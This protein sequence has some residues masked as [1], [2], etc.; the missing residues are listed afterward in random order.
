MKGEIR[1][2]DRQVNQQ[3]TSVGRPT[4]SKNKQKMEVGKLDKV[5]A[6]EEEEAAGTLEKLLKEIEGMRKQM[7]MMQERG[8]RER[9]K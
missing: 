1:K 6:G 5:L 7:E 8:W 9:S 2:S 3:M 4:G